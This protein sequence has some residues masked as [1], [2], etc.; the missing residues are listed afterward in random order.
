MSTEVSEHVISALDPL[1]G[2]GL[3][4]MQLV[5][6]DATG[7]PKE[8]VITGNYKIMCEIRVNENPATSDFL[9]FHVHHGNILPP[10]Q[11]DNVPVPNYDNPVS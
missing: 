11:Y 8:T 1:I 7:K 2:H 3:S 6:S 4:K 10:I 9:I 5:I